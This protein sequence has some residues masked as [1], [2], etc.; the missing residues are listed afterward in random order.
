MKKV[1]L[2]EVGY[3]KEG[4]LFVHKKSN[5]VHGGVNL[6][7]MIW[8]DYHTSKYPIDDEAAEVN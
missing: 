7:A 6:Y 5:Y 2:D 1:Y 4:L 8:K 3:E